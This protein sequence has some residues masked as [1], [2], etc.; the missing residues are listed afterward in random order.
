M[1]KLTGRAALME[2]LIAE[3]VKYLFGNPG[4]TELP[5]MEALQ[6]YPQLQ[7]ILALQEATAVGMADGYARA[8]GKPAFVNV[9]VAAGLA[10]SISGLYNAHRGGTPLVLTA[11]QS[12]TRSLMREPTLSG[13]LVEMCR[14]YT[15]WSGEILNTADIPMA[16]RRAF[17]AAKTPPWGPAF[18]SLPWNVLDGEAEVEIV[19]SSDGYFRTRPDEAAMEKAAALLAHAESPLMV[20]GDRVAQAGGVAQAVSLAERLGA[21][22]YSTGFTEVNYPTGHPQYLGTLVVNYPEMFK[23]VAS[24]ADVIVAVGCPVFAQFLQTEPL[25]DSHTRLVH[26]DSEVWDIEKIYPTTVGVWGDPK[27]GMALLT[28]TLEQAM[29]GTEREAA[30][31]RARTIGEEKQKQ[32]QAFVQ[33]ARERWDQ[34]PVSVERLM[35]ELAQVMPKDTVVTE[36]SVTARSAL[37][38]SID[39]NEPGSFFGMRGGALGWG[40][41]APLGIKLAMPD[42]P[43]V[44][45]V[46]D[47]SAMYT[48]QALWTAVRYNLPV[49]Y[50]ICNNGGYRILKEFLTHFYYPLLGATGRKSQFIGMNFAENPLD[51]VRLAD[52]F[53]VQGY[54]VERP[55]DLRPTLEKALGLGK[56]SVVDAV[57]QP[58]RF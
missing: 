25:L 19:P 6:D 45:I 37:N 16:V 21:R 2:M 39:F 54:R 38:N 42:R 5:V 51:F 13:N 58:G 3:G 11:G 24:K 47:G 34:T 29:S 27:I 8:T 18:L 55:E 30:Q 17:K 32:K 49:T 31:G 22:V 10:N 56:V 26:L 36:E 20:V 46:G 14:Q 50:I 40:M 28:E 44:G 48:I 33:K 15:K 4:T 7:Y 52:G 1:P 57:I 41:P 12:D 53:G 23:A 43:V 9:H 35:L